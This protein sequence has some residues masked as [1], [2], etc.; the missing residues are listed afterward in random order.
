MTMI[1]STNGFTTG[2]LVD[3]SSEIVKLG[4]THTPFTSL[5]LSKGSVNKAMSTVYSWIEKTVDDTDDI[6]FAEGSKT[7]EFQKTV[8]RELSNILQI[9]KKATEVSG[10]AEAMQS[11]LM[12]QE[13]ADRLLELKMNLENTLINGIKDD[14]SS[15]GIRRMSGLIESRDTANDIGGAHPFDV[16]KQ[17]MEKLWD[18][19][20][21]PTGEFYAFM[22]AGVKEQLDNEFV[23]SYSYAHVN[24]NFGLQVQTL[25][26]NFGV[27]HV[28]LS[29]YIP[30]KQIVLFN[31]AYTDIVTL[32][33]AHF[34][35]LAKTGDAVRGQV[36]GEYSLKVAS[37]KAV[38]LLKLI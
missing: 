26:T 30:E 7:D 37:P 12:S 23:D 29:R 27:V 1:T 31:E 5:L 16:I 6:T 17:G 34:E 15:T 38:A 2:E 8:K 4:V 32:R 28:V 24:T 10:T 13:V 22:N 25:N 3:L 9:F 36:V 21:A 33:N 20:L 19:K 35:P 18:S 14:G 11:T